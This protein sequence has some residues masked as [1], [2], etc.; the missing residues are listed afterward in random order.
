MF[1]IIIALAVGVGLPIQTSINSRLRSVLGSP[2]SASFISFSVGT[3]F[4]AIMSLIVVHTLVFLPSLLT[5]E[6]IWLWFGG[7]FGVVYL[8]GNILLFPKL[9]SVQIVIMPVLG[10]IIAGLAINNYGWFHSPISH[11]TLVSASG[12][13]LVILGVIGT[14]AGKRGIAEGHEVLD[15][16]GAAPISETTEAHGIEAW[17]WRLLGVFAGMLSASQTAINGYLGAVL[18]SKIQAAFVSF[19]VG[20]VV[21][22]IIV[23]I[24]RPPFHLHSLRTEH[25]PWWMWIGGLIGALFVLANVYLVPVIGTGLAVVITLIGLMAGGLLIDQFG[26]LGAKQNRVTVWQ[27]VS[28]IVMVA[29]VVLIRL[30]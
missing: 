19:F 29:G 1:A 8:T 23:L 27:L 14:V 20:T 9:G 13:L 10:Q 11:I 22:L 18:Q 28:L 17:L 25:H 3:I 16:E 5:S 6:P 12:A 26:W 2:F 15:Q 24:L 30:V 21:L 4:L 7:L